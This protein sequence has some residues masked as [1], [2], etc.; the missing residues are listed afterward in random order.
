MT[1]ESRLLRTARWL[2]FG[3][4][5][6]SVFSIAACQI[7][8]ALA[9]AALL[10]SGAKLRLPPV[11]LPI[12]LFMLLTVLSLAFSD[13]PGDGLSQ[14]RKFY[15]FLEM[16][17]VYSTIRDAVWVR[18]LFLAWAGAAAISSLRG[19]VQ[20]AYKL[21]DARAAGRGFYDY[22]VVERITGFMS[23]W[24]TFSGQLMIA[25]A[26][27]G[28]F[29]LF[30]PAARKRIWLWLLCGAVMCAALVLGFTRSIAFL[31]TPAAFLYLIWFWR[32]KAL[33][34][35]PV[36]CAVAFF[37]SPSWV[38]TRV[39]SIFQPGRSDSNEFRKVAWSTGWEMV[40]RHPWL[41]LG[42]ERVKA[43]FD[44][45]VPAGTPRPLPSGWYGHLHNI[46][47]HYA[48]ERG[49]PALLALLWWLGRMLFDFMAAA[50]R[51]P[52]G[53]SDVRMALHAAAAAVVAV[54][55][56]GVFELNLGDSEV[57]T[58]FLAITAC[59][60]AAADDARGNS[61]EAAVA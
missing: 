16:L 51:L 39:T 2:A 19:F 44:E 32:P 36:L 20:F 13:N 45:F 61:A 10:A 33:L 57:L 6:A 31:A 27:L 26:A 59:G 48:A 5:A 18:R 21:E 56:E 34:A 60:Y 29:L 42:P 49:I 23:H 17:V 37:A 3:S 7:L 14:L 12:G 55:V 40:R 1:P 53:R 30:S 11:W 47:V 8:L 46:Y 24:M 4:A 43:R 15:V 52:P 50:R 41:G 28:A 54:L 22:Y 9:L 35:V 38:K 58:M 25:L